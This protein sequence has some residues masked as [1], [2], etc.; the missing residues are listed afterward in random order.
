MRKA[1]KWLGRFLTLLLVLIFI[2]GA[3]VFIRVLTSG[4][5]V[6]SVFGYS[7]LK[8]SSGSMEP[9]LKTGS[10]I[11]VK[12]TD[13]DEVKAGDIICF[14]SR[15]PKISGIPNTH[16]VND[17]SVKDGERVFITKGDANPVVDDYPVYDEDI[18]GVYTRSLAS[19][20]KFAS[21][22]QSRYF[23]FFVL[24]IPLCLVVF[25]EAQNVSKAVKGKNNQVKRDGTDERTNDKE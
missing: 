18:V 14:Y 17:I 3:Y 7:F 9:T 13:A 1:K 2:V 8:V 4:D 16:R 20:T 23:F 21:I 12:S 24:L 22:V 5:K 25:L 19:T 11:V 10:V 15:D 6:P